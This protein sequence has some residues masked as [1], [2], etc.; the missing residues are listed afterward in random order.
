MEYQFIALAFISQ[1]SKQTNLLCKKRKQVLELHSVVVE[2][3]SFQKYFA[4]NDY[5]SCLLYAHENGCRWDENTCTYAAWHGHLEVI[6]YA[7]K[8]GCPWDEQTCSYAAYNGYLE[9]LKYAHENGCEWNEC[10]CSYATSN[11]QLEVLKYLHENG[12]PCKHSR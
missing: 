2:P 5:L 10:A 4:S 11:G 1:V 3:T 6:K 8:N 9:I 7:H 12:C